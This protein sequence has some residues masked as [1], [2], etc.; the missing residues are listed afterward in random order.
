MEKEEPLESRGQCSP[1]SWRTMDTENSLR[2]ESQE[3]QELSL[4]PGQGSHRPSQQDLIIILVQ[5]TI[6][7]LL[8]FPLQMR[9]F[10]FVSH[11]QIFA[12]T[13]SIRCDEEIRTDSSFFKF[14]NPLERDWVWWR[15]L[16][17]TRDSRIGSWW[18]HWLGILDVSF[19]EVGRCISKCCKTDANW[20]E[21]KEWQTLLLLTK[22][23][24]LFPGHISRLHFSACLAIMSGHD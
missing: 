22:L 7:H 24:L 17:I 12:P 11:Y 21:R 10:L 16:L 19:E 8:F 13:F 18:S 9:R 5:L 2:T 3:K 23:C 6:G 1:E 15:K 14:F 20:Y 4:L